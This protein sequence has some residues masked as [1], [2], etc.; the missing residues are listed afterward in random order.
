M[1]THH[2]TTSVCALVPYPRGTAPSQRFRIEQWLPYLEAQGIS[3][4]LV[5]FAD[6]QLME[7]L[8]KPG[9]RAAKAFANAI[10]FLLRCAD[11]TKTRRYDAVLIHR[12]ACIAGPAVLERLVAL[13][14]RPVI[15]DFDDAIFKLHTTEANRGFGWL[16]FPGKTATICRISKHVVVGNAWLADYA[17]QFNQHVT[18]IPTSIDTDHYRPEKKN[19]SNGRVVVGWT[20]SSTS[21]THLE[22]FA[23]VLRELTTR[24]DVEF[25]VISDREPL[26]PGVSYVWRPW[27]ARTEVDELSLIDIGIMPM[28]ADEW[29]RGKCAAKALQYMGMGIPTICSAVGANCDVIQHGENGLLALTSSEWITNLE[30]LVDNAALRERVGMMGRRTVEERYSMRHC[31]DLFARVVREALGQQMRAVSNA[32]KAKV[33]KTIVGVQPDIEV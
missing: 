27:S 1:R 5:P 20:G 21:Q 15:Y 4:D 18:I 28:P 7:L 16:K 32:C 14:G 10:R 30:S 33:D 22:M 31:A 2:E 19:G 6:E 24:R 9:R 11:A 25:R 8:Y 13:F 12:A 23:P 17:R 3:V 29:S 26:L